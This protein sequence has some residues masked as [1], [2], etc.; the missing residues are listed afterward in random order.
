MSRLDILKSY[1]EKKGA[2]FHEKLDAHFSDVGNANG[3][4]VNDKRNGRATLSRWEKQNASLRDMYEDIERT[5]EAIRDEENKQKVIARVK[6]GMPK[7][8]TDL[9]EEGT[10]KQW[11]KYPNIMFVEGVD[12]ARII[13]DAKKQK[14]MHKFFASIT[15]PEQRRKF[16]GVYN[17]LH[18]E[19]NNSK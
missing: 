9:I 4:P 3:Q 2:R 10:L 19:I 13:W 11:G 16:A 17:L 8:I 14:V 12:K 7:A 18:H 5:K 6:D 15:E 1:L